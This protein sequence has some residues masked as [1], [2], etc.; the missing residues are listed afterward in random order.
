MATFYV[1]GDNAS[2]GAVPPY[3]TTATGAPNFNTL[4][5]YAGTSAVNDGDTIFVV[6]ASDINDTSATIVIDKTVSVVGEYD[7][8]IDVSDSSLGVAII[9]SGCSFSNLKFKKDVSASGQHLL[10][11]D[12]GGGDSP[13]T[14]ITKCYFYDYT[15]VPGTFNSTHTIGFND[16]DSDNST[17][18]ECSFDVYG[19][20]IYSNSNDNIDIT[21]NYI[22]TS[23]VDNDRV[24]MMSN[25][26][27]STCSNNILNVYDISPTSGS[28]IDGISTEGGGDRI[29]SS[30]AI[31]MYM[32]DNNF[33]R[34]VRCYDNFSTDD[35][36]TTYLTNNTVVLSGSSV[37][38]SYGFDVQGYQFTNRPKCEM[39]NNIIYLAQTNSDCTG[40]F[41]PG[42]LD[43]K[44][45]IDYNDVYGFDSGKEF[46]GTAIIGYVD[47]MGPNT[48]N[49]EPKLVY[50][51]DSTKYDKDDI[52]YYYCDSS[53][54]CI[55][56]GK[57]YTYLGVG[58]DLNISDYQYLNIV[59][60]V[61][62]DIGQIDG[63]DVVV[64]L[65][66]STFK[67]TA[68]E[69]NNWYRD[70]NGPYPTSATYS[71]QWE[72]DYTDSYPFE[73]GNSLYN[74]DYIYVMTNKDQLDPFFGIN[75]TVNPGYNYPEYY[76]YPTSGSYDK[77]L[78]G[79][80]RLSYDPTCYCLIQDTTTSSY[81]LVN[82]TSSSTI[83]Q[84]TTD[85]C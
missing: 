46:S 2:G 58:A 59:D 8:F 6:G 22:T 82:T 68:E 51:I 4:L 40:V 75:C 43:T 18:S 79:N 16:N 17:I 55:G 21:N 74:K 70:G 23:A 56:F 25:C 24:L 14:S 35:T 45:F 3:Y 69:A 83:F 15:S 7:V 13:Y 84:N 60:T 5:G 80:S 66:N 32:Q 37:G 9:T 12:N 20:A 19:R 72:Y 67:E 81:V 11:Y 28:N 73:Q 27:S 10:A 26:L 71:N 76:A 30:N 52:R 49:I 34:G 44:F 36:L 61:T 39:Y 50:E 42:N 33:A 1:N 31:I 48:V 57:N 29:I 54:E 62:Q 38:A 65:F 64:N 53:S 78:W 47:E 63:T 77:G 41:A 85:G